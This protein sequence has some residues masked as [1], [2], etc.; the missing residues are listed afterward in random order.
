MISV[1]SIPGSQELD[2]V[3]Q[4]RPDQSSVEEEDHLCSPA[5][6][7]PFNALQDAIGLFGYEGTLLAHGLHVVY[8]DSQILLHR[9]P[10][11]Q[12]IP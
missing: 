5:S 4:V 6:H 10:L 9:A 1:F 3:L 8:Q 12:V 2:T 11:Q 7:T